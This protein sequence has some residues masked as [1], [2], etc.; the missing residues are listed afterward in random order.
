MTNASPLTL[1]INCG[2]SSLKFALFDSDRPDVLMS[3]LAERLSTAEAQIRF[4]L[5]GERIKTPLA[6][7]GLEPAGHHD[8]L[9]ALIAFLDKSQ[10]LSRIGAVGH[11]VVHG[12]ERFTGSVAITPEVL[13]DIAACSELA[14]LHNPANLIGVRA[15]LAALPHARQVA[16]FDTAFHQTMPPEAYLYALPQSYRRDFGVRRYGF[17]GTSHRFVAR[18]AI[19]W[20]NLD[21]ADSG[22]VVLHLGNGGSGTAVRNGASI[23]TTMG[24]TPLEGL[25]MGT[26]CGDVDPGALLYIARRAKLDID[27][28]DD[29]LNKESGLLGLSEL[30]NDCR[31]LEAAA[32][33]G[34]PGAKVALEVFTY[35]I[36][37]TVGALAIALPRLDAVVFTGGIGENSAGVRKAVVNRLGSLGLTLDEAA[38]ET[39]TGGVTG[40]ISRSVRP[41]ALVMPTD[42]ERMIACDTAAI[43]YGDNSAAFSK[44]T[45]DAA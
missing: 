7:R 26:R 14:P 36:A 31:T 44:F 18:R 35:R 42:E 37:K 28:L 10:W 13:S 24:L 38:N 1:V 16:V 30:S 34:H 27:G 33:D 12:G 40:V 41:C 20:L 32:K 3:G 17:H 43:A 4:D 15:A 5:G 29:L 39:T 19:D 2:S 21:P 25:V 23:D 11:R 45:K 8:A 22:L 6:G 9:N